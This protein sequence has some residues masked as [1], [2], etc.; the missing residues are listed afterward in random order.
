MLLWHRKCASQ[1]PHALQVLNN[2]HTP[3]QRFLSHLFTFY[4]LRAQSYLS[5]ISLFDATYFPEL[6]FPQ[7]ACDKCLSSIHPGLTASLFIWH[8]SWGST[9]F[10]LLCSIME[11]EML[12]TRISCPQKITWASDIFQM[13]VVNIKLSNAWKCLK[14]WLMHGKHSVIQ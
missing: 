12:V 6:S 11:L 2:F 9:V 10:W 4:M 14:Q 1:F 7:T 5:G 8:V 13:V 3:L